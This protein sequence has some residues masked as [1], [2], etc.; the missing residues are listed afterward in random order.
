MIAFSMPVWVSPSPLP[1]QD[2]VGKCSRVAQS[3]PSDWP[4]QYSRKRRLSTQ[5]TT[6]RMVAST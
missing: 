6:P 5:T 4:S 3:A 2:V 1:S